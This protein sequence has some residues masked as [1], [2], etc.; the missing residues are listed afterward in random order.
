MTNIAKEHSKR[1]G[2]SFLLEAF[3]HE[4]RALEAKINAAHATI[5]HNGTMGEVI[6]SHWIHG[7]LKRYLPDRYAVGSG[8]VIDCQ[9][10]TS[11]Q[12]DVVIYDNQYTPALLSQEDHRFIPAESVYAVLE[13]K[14]KMAGKISYAADKAASVRRLHRTSIPIRH[15]GASPYPPKAFHHIVA[16]IITLDAGWK[17]GLGGDTFKT[18]LLQTF[19]NERQLDCGCALK[20]GAFDLFNYDCVFVKDGTP[21]PDLFREKVNVKN[22]DN[23]LI[24]FVFRLLTRLQSIGTVPAVDWGCYAEVFKD[25]VPQ[26]TPRIRQL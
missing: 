2:L 19:G 8:I 3:T 5:T 17:E 12:I 6:E 24:Y 11:D 26:N 23:S 15:A 25:S 10:K 14:P 4:Q 20:E 7:F 1:D 13:V 9:G 21:S 22:A 18:N 16:G